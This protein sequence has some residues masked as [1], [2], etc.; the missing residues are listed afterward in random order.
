VPLCMDGAEVRG[1]GQPSLIGGVVP[2]CIDGAEVRGFSRPACESLLLK[3]NARGCL[4]P[5]RSSF[6]YL[7]MILF[8]KIYCKKH[9]GA[10]E[11]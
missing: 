7:S 5:R 4:N 2:L 11:G 6:F 10:I 8:R 9:S 1:F 3:H